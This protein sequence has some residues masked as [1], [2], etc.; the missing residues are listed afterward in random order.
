MPEK[1]ISIPV[2]IKWFWAIIIT[3]LVSVALAVGIIISL[4]AHLPDGEI[5]RLISEIVEIVKNFNF[6]LLLQIPENEN[7]HKLISEIAKNTDFYLFAGIVTTYFI[8][9]AVIIYFIAL[10]TG[11]I[12]IS[13]AELIK[14][15]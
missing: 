4:L 7:Y 1:T 14:N 13:E 15:E 8:A 11:R 6:Y 2:S 5:Y 9:L 12:K 10:K 3:A